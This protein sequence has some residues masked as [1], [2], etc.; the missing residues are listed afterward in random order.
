MGDGI[1]S[2][3]GGVNW[4]GGW[5]RLFCCVGVLVEGFRA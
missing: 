4:Q 2:G 5:I 1:F 3:G